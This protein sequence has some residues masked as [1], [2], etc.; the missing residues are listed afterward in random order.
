MSSSKPVFIERIVDLDSLLKK[1]SYFLFGPRQ[2]GKSSLIK[3]TLSSAKIYDLL[4]DKTF[5]EFNSRPGRLKEEI[6]AKDKW[7]VIDEIQRIPHLLNEVHLLIEDMGTRFL[8]TG[9]SARKLRSK[10]VNLLGGRAREAHLYPFVTAELGPRFDLKRALY[11]GLIPSIYF[12]DDVK[13]DLNA[14]ISNYLTLEIAAEALTRNIPA[15]S[16]FLTVAA[17]CNASIVNFTEVANDAQVK[18]TTVY[19]Y[20]EILK[21]TYLMRELSPFLQGKKRKPI[22]SSKYYFFDVGVARQLQGREIYTPQTAEYGVAFETFMINE[23]FAYS[24]YIQP[25]KLNFWRSTSKLEVDLIVDGRFAIEIKGKS[26]INSDDI[27]TLKAVSQEHSFDRLFC[28][29]LEPR[30]RRVGGIEIIP[31]QEFLKMLWARKLIY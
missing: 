18:R 3:R 28:V 11:A 29:C 7:V 20:F 5:L 23:F 19:E 6:T 12:S 10:G 15:F 14:Y 21:D 1:R 16:R 2:T 27:K 26:H 30:P 13:A 8:L 17:L 22:A 9:S 25:L 24:D 31:Y 4:D